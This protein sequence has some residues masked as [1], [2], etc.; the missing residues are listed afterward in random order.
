MKSRRILIIILVLLFILF[1]G[2][3]IFLLTSKNNPLHIL[4]VEKYAE[5][6]EWCDIESKD[7]TLSINCNALLIDIGINENKENCFDTQILTNNNGI[8]EF[9]ICGDNQNLSY[10]NEILEYKKLKPITIQLLYKKTN[11][12]NEYAFTQANIFALNQGTFQSKVNE[13]IENLTK[14]DTASTSIKN[15]VD[16]CPLPETLPSYVTETNKSSYTSFYETNKNN[17]SYYDNGYIYNIDDTQIIA[18]MS[19]N[20]LKLIDKNDSCEFLNIGLSPDIQVELAKTAK[21]PQFGKLSD[22][23]DMYAMKILSLLYSRTD[24]VSAESPSSLILFVLNKLNNELDISEDLYCYTHSILSRS[25][26][27]EIQNYAQKM[28]DS[29]EQYSEVVSSPFCT[30]M[31]NQNT[32][33]NNGLYLRI[34]QSQSNDDLKILGKCLNLYNEINE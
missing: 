29:L 25:K 15:S 26:D 4:K 6:L 16:F 21:L 11:I 20:I 2:A 23:N 22:D 28:K 9:T 1:A 12:F 3:G 10:T 30:K 5:T 14:L 33:D 27:S 7:D 8:K 24:D 18:L 19:C 31:L 13:D 17:N 34:I 32:F